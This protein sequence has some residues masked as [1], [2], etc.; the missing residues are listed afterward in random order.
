MLKKMGLFSHKKK[1]NVGQL[2]DLPT[3]NDL[4]PLEDKPHDTSVPTYESAFTK[5]GMDSGPVMGEKPGKQNLETL[6]LPHREAIFTKSQPNYKER[7]DTSDLDRVLPPSV[8]DEQ[9]SP[10]KKEQQFEPAF[11]APKK[12][13]QTF[14]K[15][16][17]TNYKDIVIPK[18]LRDNR[19]VFVQIDDYKDALNSVEVLKQKIREVDYILD[20]MT[21]IKSQEQLEISN[22]ETTLNKIKERLV[23]IDKKLFE[24]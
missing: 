24:I 2:P 12:A 23:D 22:C 7:M 17:N 21:E 3:F 5:Q 1:R 14:P 10:F 18:K 9:G 11:V 16:G 4:P 19:P 6:D 20:R 15:P 13:V 8:H